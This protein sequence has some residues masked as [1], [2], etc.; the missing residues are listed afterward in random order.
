M[1]RCTKCFEQ[2]EDFEG[3]D[4]WTE[5]E[6]DEAWEKLYEKLDYDYGFPWGEINLS[7]LFRWLYK[8]KEHGEI[9]FT[10]E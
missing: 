2:L 3:E 8:H 7:S 9:E 1:L 4:N 6:Y 10:T 5:D